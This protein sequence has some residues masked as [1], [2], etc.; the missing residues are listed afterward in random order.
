ME[1]TPISPRGYERLG[2]RESKGTACELSARR[3]NFVFLALYTS[4]L[5]IFVF[6]EGG[7]EKTKN[8]LRGGRVAGKSHINDN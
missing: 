8:L 6:E 3:K 1:S 4:D 7:W 2:P 5:Y